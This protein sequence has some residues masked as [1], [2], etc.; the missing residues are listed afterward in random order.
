MYYVGATEV[1]SS[2]L[3][4]A[5]PQRDLN[6]KNCIRNSDREKMEISKNNE[7]SVTTKHEYDRATELKAFDE[8]KDGVK[9]LVDASVT[10]IPRIFHHKFDKESSSTST[11]ITKLDV[12]T[13]DLVD[14]HQ[15]PTR[16]KIVVENIREASE[17]CGFFQIVNH[18]IEVSVL[19]EM[20]NGAIRFF[21]Q[22]SEVKREVYSRD[23]LRPF[24]YN[25]NFDLYSSPAACWRDT[26][27]C[28][29]APKS[30]KPEDLP[31]VCRDIMLEYRKQ[32]MNLGNVLFE[33]LSEALGLS[34][35]YLN[36]MKCNEGLAIVFHYYPPCPEPELTLGGTKHTDIDFITVLLQD[37]IG[38]LQVLH[39]NNW[40][41]V[42]PLPGALVINIGDLLQ[43]ITNDKFKSVEHRVVANHVGPRVSVASFFRSFEP[44]TRLLCPIKE[45]VSEV[46]PPMYKKTTVRDYFE[47]CMA[48]GSDGT[49]SLPYFKIGNF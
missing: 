21:E 5:D 15:D 39:E 34:P 32:V 1:Q 42:S 7:I 33:L 4:D 35:N 20:K 11:N 40:I 30:P 37:H 48:R 49:P 6:L 19:D 45:L 36:D 13:I 25:S 24:V 31:S 16:R 9:G 41:D 14:I 3:M 8:T 2:C 47:F 10:K 22:D 27:Y 29:M 26:F 46:N 17:K 12:P 43:L 28:L 18:G 44:S 23:H 38:G